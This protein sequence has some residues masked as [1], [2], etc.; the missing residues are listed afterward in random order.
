MQVQNGLENYG[1]W[2][3]DIALHIA[4]IYQTVCR[5]SAS[6]RQ[7][8]VQKELCKTCVHLILG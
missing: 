4:K 2:C 3:K 7:R 8:F 6:E 5:G 1:T